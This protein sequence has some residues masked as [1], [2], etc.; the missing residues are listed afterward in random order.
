[1]EHFYHCKRLWISHDYEPTPVMCVYVCMCAVKSVVCTSVHFVSAQKVC[2][3]M[4]RSFYRLFM[5]SPHLASPRHH[6]FCS[7]PSHLSSIIPKSAAVIPKMKSFVNEWLV[8][9]HWK[10]NNRTHRNQCNWITATKS[11][12]SLFHFMDLLNKSEIGKL[13]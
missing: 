2:V 3:I 10:T 9:P 6:R 1:M 13:L 8:L 12:E 7:P 4:K 5:L 11:K